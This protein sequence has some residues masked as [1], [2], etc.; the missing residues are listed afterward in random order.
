MSEQRH[1]GFT[2]VETLVSLVVLGFIVAGLAQGFRFGMAAWDRQVRTIDRDSALDSTDRILRALLSRMVPGDNPNAP[3][4]VGNASRLVF[5]AELPVNAPAIPTRLADLSLGGD[6]A[7]RLVL[8]WTPH[9]HARLL[10]P[11]VVRKATLLSGV[12]QVKFAY[13]RA[14]SGQQ[15][16]GWVDQ[17]RNADPPML[18]R[19]HFELQN[20]SQHWPDVIVAPMCEPD[21]D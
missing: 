4:V 8:T 13:F 14:P 16:A 11:P 2:L 17:W 18:V 1:A 7:H 10:A 19:V 21:D 12:R 3:A 15:P 5:T 6:A 20:P 9:L